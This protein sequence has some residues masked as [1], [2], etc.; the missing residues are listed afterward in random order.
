MAGHNKWTNIK[1][2]KGAQDKKKSRDFF[3]VAQMIR[4]AVKSSGDGN[5]DTNPN[6]RLALEKARAVNM[7]KEN[8]TRAINRALG[9]SESGTAVQEIIYEGYG[10]GGVA[11]MVVAV[12]DNVQRTA[13]NIRF[14]FS[15]NGGSLAAPGSAAFLFDRQV[16]GSF[17]PTMTI[18][19]PDD[20]VREQLEE[21]CAL[22]EED[23]DV[24]EVTTNV[25][26]GELS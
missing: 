12:T 14:L 7:P 5:P 26:S 6:L 10:P 11:F 8:V 17:L 16:D 4:S 13:A 24:E 1:N 18:P 9:K 21:L 3:L 23:E 2:R 19:V 25:A 15:R 20:S 22:L